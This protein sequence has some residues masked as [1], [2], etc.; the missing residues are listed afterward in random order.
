MRSPKMLKGMTPQ[1]IRAYAPPIIGGVIVGGWDSGDWRTLN[2]DTLRQ[3]WRLSEVMQPAGKLDTRNTVTATLA[4][5]AVV[6]D[7]ANAELT[8][9]AGELWFIN[10]FHVMSPA[11]T[12]AE[13]QIVLVN[14]RI[15]SWV[16]DD[17][18][19][20]AG[21]LFWA[22]GRG[23]VGVDNSYPGFYTSAPWLALENMDTP[24]RLVGGDKVTLYAT[25]TGAVCSATLSATLTPYGFKAVLQG[26]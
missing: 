25:L 9:P 11:Q 26:V 3:L 6:N 5:T 17:D 14:F 18:S 24:L 4:A 15:S 12:A 19:N 8:V 7:V 16:D 13:G 23:T 1:Q 22:A 21:K 10:Y 2:L 20:A